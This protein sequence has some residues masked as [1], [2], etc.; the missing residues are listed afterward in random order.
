MKTK[1]LNTRQMALF[2]L[3]IAV[4]LAAY[5]ISTSHL[6]LSNKEVAIGITLDLTLTLPVFYF[7]AIR[8]TK[9]PKITVIPVFVL[10]LILSKVLLP[11]ELHTSANLIQ[12]YVLPIVELTVLSIIGYKIYSVR[13][14][15]KS[16][17]EGNI[18][19][20]EAFHKAAVEVTKNER[21]ANFL[22]TEI[23]SFAYAFFI[24]RKP[25]KGENQFSI[26]KESGNIAVFGGVILALIAE[27]FALHFWI[28]MYSPVVAWIL[29]IAS[30][31][32]LIQVIG[33]IKAMKRRFVSVKDG[34][35]IYRY[36]IFGKAVIDINQ[37]EKME[38]SIYDLKI[39][40]D[41]KAQHAN[42][43]NE[44]ERTN[45]AIY[46]KEEVEI[47]KMYGFKKSGDVILFQVDEVQKFMTLCNPI[48]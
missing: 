48:N 21:L 18:D 24:W 6:L 11:E 40:A 28:E 2:L 37:I 43:L 8:K 46:L 39:P 22:T 17:K 13:K 29:T 41:R 38:S 44:L 34:Q 7:L 47:E 10:G 1:K 42:L 33:H 32:F 15:Y 35:I 20:Y 19:F 45:L 25:K 16:A 26:Y 3:P 14:A 27:G 5:Y 12:L 9:I 36:G 31:Y 23:S 30:A 4:L